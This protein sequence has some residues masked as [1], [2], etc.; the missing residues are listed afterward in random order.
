[1]LYSAWDGDS[2][3]EEG[4]GMS[5]LE[6]EASSLEA[7]PRQLNRPSLLGKVGKGCL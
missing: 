2:Q 4:A 7:E 1:V 5:I 3:P 6:G